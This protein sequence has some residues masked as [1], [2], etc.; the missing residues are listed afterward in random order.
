M[1]STPLHSITPSHN[2]NRHSLQY[3]TVHHTPP[4]DNTCYST[5][6]H[7]RTYSL[8][9]HNPQVHSDVN[10]QPIQTKVILILSRQRRGPTFATLSRFPICSLPRTGTLCLSSLSSLVLHDS[11]HYSSPVTFPSYPILSYPFY[12]STPLMPAGT[13]RPATSCR[14]ERETP[15]RG[16]PLPSCLLAPWR[17]ISYCNDPTGRNPTYPDL[18]LTLPNLTVHN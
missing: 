8:H 11:V 4:H 1:H 6:L 7:S 3:M 10:I 12:A 14:E 15:S 18:K 9:H 13:S 17:I 16:F 2:T 5:P